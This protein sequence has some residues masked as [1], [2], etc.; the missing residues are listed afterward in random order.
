MVIVGDTS[1]ANV[2]DVAM[3]EVAI[4]RIRTVDPQ[5]RIGVVTSEAARPATHDIGPVDTIPDR[6]ALGWARDL[7]VWR[8][9]APQRMEGLAT[10]WPRAV[11]GLVGTARRSPDRAIVKR[12]VGAVRA[13]DLLVVAGQGGWHDGSERRAGRLVDVI[14]LAH[15]ASVPVLMLGQG[16]GPIR[17][18]DLRIGVGRALGHVQAVAVRD[19]SSAD[20]VRRL[21]GPGVRVEVTGDDALAV[22]AG[23]RTGDRDAIGLS[24]RANAASAM[25]ASAAG[26][27]AAAVHRAAGG[28]PVVAVPMMELPGSV[29]DRDVLSGALGVDLPVHPPGAVAPAVEA[30]GRC[31]VVV[32]GTYHGAVLSAA[33][34]IPVV[35]LAWSDYYRAKMAGVAAQMPAGSI[36]VVDGAA[37]DLGH[38]IVASVARLSARV[39]D[40]GPRL[41]S[42]SAAQAS[43]GAAFAHHEIALALRL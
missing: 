29:S 28:A 6:A 25:P 7:D 24:L 19:P 14:R 4:D 13:A 9:R 12:Y 8:R 36:E 15:A 20:E 27:V 2:G 17:R 21:G 38:R 30:I 11:G 22:P 18:R 3:A 35:A 39:G 5:A 32:S 41:R 26:V 23:P 42:A 34:G 37:P 31:H 33:A 43:A 1:L 40:L 10:R 16:V